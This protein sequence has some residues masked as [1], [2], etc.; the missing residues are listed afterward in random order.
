MSPTAA[1]NERL[2]GR[3]RVAPADRLSRLQQSE[4]E[5][6]PWGATRERLQSMAV[7]LYREAVLPLLLCLPGHFANATVTTVESRAG[8]SGV[9]RF[10]PTERFPAA[11][12]LFCGVRRAPADRGLRVEY[13]L[14][15]IPSLLGYE[16]DDALNVAIEQL[17]QL[18]AVAAWVEARLLGFVDTYLQL[19]T[20]S[21]YQARNARTD[22]VCGAHVWTTTAACTLEYAR[23]TLHF[24]SELCRSRFLEQPERFIS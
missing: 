6:H 3:V 9:V 4:G 12:T 10:E 24:C 8:Q 16:A 21:H 19:E 17:D 2:R 13:R 22:P 7:S 11:T 14:E 5:L 18:Q 15:I 20:N 23:R 1:F